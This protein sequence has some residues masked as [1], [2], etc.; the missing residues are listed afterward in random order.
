MNATNPVRDDARDD[1]PGLLTCP[2]CG[3]RAS[4]VGRRRFCSHAC[5]QKAYRNRRS[6]PPP[7]P[8]RRANGIYE[9]LDCGELQLG[10]Q[11][12]QQCGIFGRRIGTG[13]DCPH[14]GDPVAI[15]E[16]IG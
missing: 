2:V 10:E 3:R 16:L 9:C 6:T 14:C 5:R 11:R 4:R 7:Q 1:H 8:R 15:E 12:C 13:A